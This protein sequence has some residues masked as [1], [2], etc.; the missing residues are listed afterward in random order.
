MIRIFP[1]LVAST[2]ETQLELWGKPV[3][4]C[5]VVKII[6]FGEGR[7]GKSFKQVAAVGCFEDFDKL[8][9]AE[10]GVHLVGNKS[11]RKQRAGKK[12]CT[13]RTIQQ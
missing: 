9:R 12:Y 3:F 6:Y 11:S 4:G 10:Y 5:C 7:E 8:I 2:R 1:S 13:G